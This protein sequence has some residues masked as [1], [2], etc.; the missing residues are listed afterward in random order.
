MFSADEMNVYWTPEGEME[1]IVPR[2]D[3]V[4]ACGDQEGWYYD[5]PTTPEWIT[6]CPT[7]CGETQGT[8]RFESGCMVVK[9]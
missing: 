8:V 3:N 9:C 2:V 1:R 7:S 6:L 5:D 4:S